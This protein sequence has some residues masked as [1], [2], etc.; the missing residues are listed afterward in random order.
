MGLRIVLFVLSLAIVVAN[1]AGGELSEA[2]ENT[3]HRIKSI[4]GLSREESEML[5][6]RSQKLLNP[7][8]YIHFPEML[9]DVDG[10]DKEEVIY[11]Y[12]SVMLADVDGDDK[13]EA[14][15]ALS[16]LWRGEG[17]VAIFR[18]QGEDYAIW[19]RI[20]SDGS[21]E[22]ETV[23]LSGSGK[24]ALI[25]KS[26]TGGAKSGTWSIQVYQWNGQGF[27]RIWEGITWKDAFSMNYKSNISAEVQYIDLNG[28]GSREIVR[29]GVVYYSEWDKRP[30]LEAAPLPE[31]KP[32][33]FPEVLGKARAEISGRSSSAIDLSKITSGYEAIYRFR[34]T[35][36]YDKEFGCYIRYKAR[37]LQDTTVDGVFIAKGTRVGILHTS[38]EAHYNRYIS[39]DSV[40]LPDSRVIQ[41]DRGILSRIH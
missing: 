25:V 1:V 38:A 15:V 21:P 18:R 8:D 23:D 17:I 4:S 13:E 3:R 40:V 20:S 34:E 30:E 10:D 14:I 29:T 16:I 35:F 28:D 19:D 41:L 26:L 33:Q 22:V 12:A 32:E 11:E 6:E 7:E 36:F 5:V 24:Q 31:M 27:P 2:E 39:S 37:V 9:A